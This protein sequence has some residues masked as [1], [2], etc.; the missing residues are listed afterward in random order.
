M[1]F[2]GYYHTTSWRCVPSCRVSICTLLSPN[3]PSGMFP[4]GSKTKELSDRERQQQQ[5]TEIAENQTIIPMFLISRFLQCYLAGVAGWE[6]YSK[7][8][9]I[10]FS[11]SSNHQI[12]SRNALFR[13]Q[14]TFWLS[15][16]LSSPLCLYLPVCV[17]VCACARACVCSVL[18]NRRSLQGLPVWVDSRIY[19]ENNWKAKGIVWIQ[20][21]SFCSSLLLCH[22]CNV[23]I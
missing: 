17:C 21:H 18:R 22:N 14:V 1:W 7:Q 20:S 4:P 19:H 13:S 8:P 16:F 12:K 15:S 11:L 2:H 10:N 6:L 3:V 5:G 23:V 9:A